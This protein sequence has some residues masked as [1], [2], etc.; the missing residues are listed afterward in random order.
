MDK[1]NPKIN[2]QHIIFSAL[3]GFALGWLRLHDLWGAIDW[4][5]Y[6]ALLGSGNDGL[7]FMRQLI[8]RKEKDDKNP[9]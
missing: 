6:G 3:I 5:V 1:F 8:K 9:V 4:C 2:L 7:S